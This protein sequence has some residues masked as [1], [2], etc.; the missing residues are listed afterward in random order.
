MNSLPSPSRPTKSRREKPHIE[1]APDQPLTTQGKPRARVYVACVQWYVPNSHP[2]PR[3]TSKSRSRKIRCDGAKPVCHNCFPSLQSQPIPASTDATPKRRGPDKTPGARQRMAREARQESDADP[4]ASRRRRRKKHDS[5]SPQPQ[6]LIRS[7][8]DPVPAIRPPSLVLDPQLVDMPPFQLA[9]PSPLYPPSLTPSRSLLSD[10]LSVL[11]DTAL[12]HMTSSQGL[13]NTVN[14]TSYLHHHPNLTLSPPHPRCVLSFLCTTN[15]IPTPALIH[16]RH[17]SNIVSEPSLDLARQTW[18]DSLLSLYSSSSPSISTSLSKRQL[19]AN[20]ITS[21]LRFLFR[22]SVYWFSFV[23]IPHFFSIYFDSERRVRMQPSFLPAALAIATF[24]Q[25]SEAGFGREGRRKAML[26]RDV[27]QGALEASLNARWIDEEL[28][29][30]AWLLALFE[31]CAHP[32]HTSERC[33]SSLVMLDTIIRTLSLTFIDMEDPASTRFLLRSVPSVAS[34]PQSW[35][36]LSLAVGVD[37]AHSPYTW[38]GCSCTSRTLGERWAATDEYTPLWRSSP[39]WDNS[40]SEA[41]IRKETCR[42]LCWSTLVL[43]AGHTSYVTST[44][45]MPSEFFILEPANFAL[46]FPGEA[47]HSPGGDSG[48]DTRCHALHWT[49]GSKRMRLRKALNSHGCD[50]ER[51]FLFQGREYLFNV[52]SLVTHDFQRYVAPG[53]DDM[54]HIFHEKA[55][56]WL[57][58]QANVAQRIVESLAAVTGHPSHQLMHRPFYAFWFMNQISRALSVW[59]CDNSLTLA[60]DVCTALFKPVDYLSALWPFHAT[61]DTCASLPLHNHPSTSTLKR[62]PSPSFDGP[63]TEITRKRLKEDPSEDISKMP[64]ASTSK[65]DTLVE[66]LAQELQCGCCAELVY[67]PVV[68]SPCQHFFC[69]SCCVLW[70]KNGG[71]N[72]PACRGVSTFV[73]PSRPLQTIVDVLL[74][75]VPSRARTERERMQADEI[76]KAGASMRIPTP[77]EA[78]P[79]PNLNQNSDYARPCPHCVSH[80]PYG[81]RCPQ[82]IIDFSVDPEQAW[83]LEDGAPPGHAH[84]GNCEM[85]LALGA[86]VT[87][88]CDFCQVSFCGINVQGRCVASP[89]VSQHPH[90]MTDVGDLIQSSEVY[91]CFENNT[92]EVEIMLDYLTNGQITPRQIYCDIVQHLQSQP[93]EF[94]SLIE[95]ELFVDMHSVAA[96]TDDNPTAP[97]TRI[98]RHCSTEVLLSGLRDWWIR[99]RHKG[100]LDAA[101]ANRPDCEEG[102]SCSRQKDL[103]HAKE[104]NHL[105]STS[106]QA[107]G[108]SAGVSERETFHEVEVPQ[109]DEPNLP[110]DIRGTEEAAQPSSSIET[111]ASLGAV[112]NGAEGRSNA[113]LP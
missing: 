23:N 103:A 17:P 11:P 108:L 18:W 111:D 1:L 109:H 80:N 62:P 60:L 86:P 25:S 31:V 79:E 45:R 96:G 2:S 72:C 84:C 3:L 110:S 48:K 49:H 78:S 24:F 76:Y 97:R 98:C 36:N 6:S 9:S 89:L 56:E 113:P 107:P 40:W 44:R 13:H 5:L 100:H 87:T 74:R 38:R 94:R 99:E 77:R 101:I 53:S 75:A 106:A 4:V 65:Y 95:S 43:T 68:V 30:A 92:V 54:H 64:I 71:T 69:G 29:Q 12:R 63:D 61:P 39:G 55:K 32:D 20:H 22:S 15:A 46:L 19:S 88:K 102:L 52:R 10:P 42:R 14:Y 47:I 66:D 93:N 73:T 83:H 58:H 91:E 16:P 37:N 50:L 104:F 27:A 33:S 90:N 59:E 112:D 81:W 85:L 57:T 26:L 41:E 8:P 70:I 21:D 35:P 51:T 7:S 105:V 34:A 67:R 28:A 82:P